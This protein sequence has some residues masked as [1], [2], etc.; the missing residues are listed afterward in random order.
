VLN[1]NLFSAIVL[2]GLLAIGLLFFLKASTKDRT[3][4]LALAVVDRELPQQIYTYLRKRG[5]RLVNPSPSAEMLVWRGQ[6]QASVFLCIFLAVL[7]GIGL[8]SL[9]LVLVILVPDLWNYQINLVT[10]S[11]GGLGAGWFYWRGA[12][13]EEEV[14]ITCQ[15]RQSNDFLVIEAHRDELANLQNALRGH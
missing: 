14:K 8:G 1:S 3:A 13:R 5:Y 10:M 7:A 12:N 4:S 11:L 15:Q 9:G 2:T 6:V